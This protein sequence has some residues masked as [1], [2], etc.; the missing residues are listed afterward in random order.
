MK[1]IEVN[2]EMYEFLAN[3]SKEIK[4]QDN[5]GTKSPYFFQVQ[6]EEECEVPDGCGEKV[7]VMDGQICLRT[8]EDIKKAVFEYNDWDLEDSD[9]NIEYSEIHDWDLGHLLFKAGYR[10]GYVSIKHKYS[11]CFLT[12]KACHEYLKEDAHN[13]TNPKSYLFYA[14]RN[15]EMEMLFKFFEESFNE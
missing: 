8:E 6:E 13:L 4:T 10:M 15:K 14:P 1:T 12:E 7:W 11:N 2:D 9:K 5:R 3:L